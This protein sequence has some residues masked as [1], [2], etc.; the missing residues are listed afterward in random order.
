MIDD[1]ITALT[2]GFFLSFMIG[3]VFFVILETSVIKGAKAA[4]TLDLGVIFSDIV[5]ILI[6]YFSTSQL[7]EKLKDEPGMYIFGGV[8]L[9]TY[10][11]V[12][13]LKSK[14][15]IT[16]N[17]DPTIQLIQRNNYIRLF[18]KG[19][20]LNFINIGVLGFWLGII[21]VFGPQLEMKTERFIGFF[22]AV[23]GTYFIVDLGKIFLAKK[24]NNKLT[25]LRIY[26]FKRFISV[27]IIVF[28]VILLL[29]GTVPEDIN[30]RIENQIERRIP[31]N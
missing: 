15:V 18:I 22:T 7:L 2:L 16:A 20:L 24:L 10:G 13:F 6:A 26:R 31:G 9:V 12:S 11:V 8:I 27:L 23:L 1:L 25:P 21:L 28:G 19:F 4:V 29:K 3:P 17:A 5:F 14:S 30:N